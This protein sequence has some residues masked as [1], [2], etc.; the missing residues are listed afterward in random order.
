MGHHERLRH[1]IRCGVHGLS[2]FLVSAICLAFADTLD[3]SLDQYVH[4]TWTSEQGLPQNSVQTIVQTTDG[5]LWMGTEEGLVRF[6]G[7]RFSV[8]NKANTPAFKHN[9]VKTLCQARNGALWAGTL[10][11]GALA[12][13]NGQFRH[14]SI[15]DGL[16]N[17]FVNAIVEDKNGVVWLGTDDGLNAFR[18]GKFIRVDKAAGLSSSTISTLAA[19]PNGGLWIGTNNG[20]NRLESS[21]LEAA[22]TGHAGHVTPP[23]NV[24]GHL[25]ITG[26][27]SS[28]DGA[29]W[30]GTQDAGLFRVFGGRV[31]HYTSDQGLPRAPILS[32]LK[33][34]HQALW[35]GTGAGGVCLL[36][37]E[38]DN[39]FA[40]DSSSDAPSANTV[41]SLYQDREQN[42]WMGTESGGLNRFRDG[43]LITYGAKQ[44]ITGAVRSIYEDPDH[45][46]W[47]GTD[48]GLKRFHDGVVTAYRTPYGPANNYAWTVMKDKEGNVWVG[49]NQG[50]LNEF[51][52]AGIKNYTTR[53]GLPDN[54]VHAV[55]EDHAGRIWIGTERGGMAVFTDGKFRT[56]T[57]KDGLAD[58]RVWCILEDHQGDLLF[59]SDT[60][61]TR[62]HNGRFTRIKTESVADPDP[63]VGSVIYIYEDA[64]HVLWIGTYGSGLKRLEN[65]KLTTYNKANGLF[66]DTAWNILEDGHNRLWMSSNFGIFRADKREL[67]E[68]ADGKI[69]RIHS[70][71]YGTSDGMPVAE[72][73][74]GSQN[75]GWKAADGRLLFSC[76]H[77]VVA[78]N[79][80]KLKTN[81]LPPPVAIEQA[82][83]N[84]MQR[85]EGVSMPVGKGE[86]EFH[87]AAMSYVA[88]EKVTFRYKLEGFDSNWIDAANRRDAYYTNIPAG[89]YRFRVIAANNDGVWNNQGASFSLYL[90]PRF[91][92]TLWF[93]LLSALF[94]LV[95]ARAAYVWRIRQLEKREQALERLV[96]ERTAALE[97]EIS[98]HQQTETE[99]QQ[100]IAERKRATEKAEAATRAKS[101][102][103]ANM[104]HEIRTPLNGV[105]GMLELVGGTSLSSDQNELVTMAQHSAGALLAVINDI[106]DF[107]K[108]EAGKLQFESEPFDLADTVLNACRTTAIKAHQKKL[109]LACFIAP[110]VPCELIGDSARLRQVLLN[111]LGNAIKFTETGEVIL[112]TDL[113]SASGSEVELRF[114]IADT[115]VG[116][117]EEKQASIFQAFSQADTSITRRFGG[118]GLGLTICSRIVGFMGGRI[119]L[120]SEFGRGSTFYFTARFKTAAGALSC[121]KA[122]V[123]PDLLNI[124]VLIVDDNHTNG[125]IVKRI[126]AGF[127]ADAV[128]ATT[129]HDAVAAVRAASGQKMPFQLLLIDCRMPEMSGA[130]LY[131][132]LRTD[133]GR[134]F[135]TVMMLESDCYNTLAARCREMGISTYI[136][137]P[138]SRREL[139]EAVRS[140][141]APP[142]NTRATVPV[143]EESGRRLNILLAED[144]E[145]NQK[146]AVKML[147][148]MGHSVAIARNGV[149]VIGKARQNNFDLIFMDIHMPELDGFAA[150]AAIRQWEKPRGEHVPII[151]MTASVM[152]GDRERCLEAQMDGYTPKPITKA[153]LE[154]IIKQFASDE[155]LLETR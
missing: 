140:A 48:L 85:P 147:E 15:R 68:Y 87:F 144:N 143:P 8:F 142:H 127:G 24:L 91:Y 54:Q 40:C 89:H 121:P 107:S 94:A 83:I 116:I 71:S 16:S 13:A 1:L 110:S 119:W 131:E 57:S 133:Q 81:P 104:S 129:A 44:G 7:V 152:S 151:A 150:T 154:A 34:A 88:P 72:C 141:L 137:K 124:R 113:E 31:V 136:M 100:E 126:L 139:L 117:P 49:T 6:D 96:A 63:L 130:D 55:Y 128:T 29:L 75:S 138:V 86:L 123:D 25:P 84:G 30:A 134:A 23:T 102:F 80:D 47:I 56:Y 112:Q 17:N 39:H 79:P 93:D 21:V 12:Y 42:V 19:D 101:E 92:Q 149:E 95:L 3:K 60:G 122:L 105:M 41:L 28:P 22:E 18:S 61:L 50:G 65:G 111:L 14:Y 46:L 74:G 148:T 66:D 82:T 9:D 62:L 97:R 77:G 106:L 118:T 53:D 67:N 20:L 10:G 26:L 146:V 98:G 135:R 2:A 114:S 64:A 58:N 153:S 155:V 132:M 108:I 125:Q 36:H 90:Q 78:V 51:T 38:R 59:G 45:S 52:R 33:D 11:G 27:Y 32:I 37:L 4:T 103:V 120:R 43:S 73:N 76:V 69:S 115:G 109:E 35:V 5:Y 70:V 145:I 99:L